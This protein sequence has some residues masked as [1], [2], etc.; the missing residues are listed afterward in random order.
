MKSR[1]TLWMILTLVVLG[2][3]YE[4]N[5]GEVPNKTLPV[6]LAD[7]VSMKNQSLRLSPSAKINSLFVRHGQT[8]EPILIILVAHDYRLTQKIRNIFPT[9]RTPLLFSISSM[10]AKESNL[11]LDLFRFRQND[12]IWS[13]VDRVEKAWFVLFKD[14]KFGGP[15]N[16]GEIQRGL[17][18][19]PE[20][21]DLQQ[22]ITIAY[23]K[24]ERTLS[25]M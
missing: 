16:Q 20:W 9:R 12:K 15:I 14:A 22:P 3:S 8:Q 2:L 5:Y 17:V 24:S 13:P 23:T 10:P 19:L 18:L 25:L 1:S 7:H 21:F 11:D 6:I 4:G